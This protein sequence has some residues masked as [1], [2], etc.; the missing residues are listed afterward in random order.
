LRVSQGDTLESTFQ[1]VEGKKKRGK[2]RVVFM[3]GTFSRK[4][5][6]FGRLREGV[7][8]KGSKAMGSENI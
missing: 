6:E 5:V 7:K 8:E 4:A 3:G 1:L 2:L